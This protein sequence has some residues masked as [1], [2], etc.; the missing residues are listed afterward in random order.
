MSTIVVL[1]HPPEVV[2]VD[3]AIIEDMK[4]RLAEPR[5]APKPTSIFDRD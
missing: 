1:P 4:R 3:P 5:P 2:D